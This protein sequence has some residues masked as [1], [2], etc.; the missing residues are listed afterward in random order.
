M[1]SMMKKGCRYMIPVLAAFLIL[2]LAGGA[3]AEERQL[4]GE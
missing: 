2:L 1:R 4:K 3:L